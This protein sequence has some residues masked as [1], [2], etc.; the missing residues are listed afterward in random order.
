MATGYWQLYRYNPLMAANGLDPYILD[1]LDPSVKINDL[2]YHGT[3][4]AAETTDDLDASEGPWIRVSDEKA[5]LTVDYDRPDIASLDAFLDGEDRYADLRI[6][7]PDKVAALRKAL[8]DHYMSTYNL[9][10]NNPEAPA[11]NR[12]GSP[13]TNT[14]VSSDEK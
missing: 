4:S 7:A 13:A 2:P 1:S 12:P 3:P 6:V 5:K 10:I 14:P 11:A 9:L 8:A